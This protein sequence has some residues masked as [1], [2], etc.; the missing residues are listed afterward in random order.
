MVKKDSCQSCYCWTNR[1][2][3]ETGE[4]VDFDEN[5]VVLWNQDKTQ[6]DSDLASVAREPRDKGYNKIVL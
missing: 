1:V 2:L 5:A 3:K 6:E 4:Y